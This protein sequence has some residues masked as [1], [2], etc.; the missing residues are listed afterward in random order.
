MPHFHN[1]LGTRNGAAFKTRQHDSLVA[2]QVNGLPSSVVTLIL[3]SSPV[4]RRLIINLTCRFK[5]G[6]RGAAAE[7]VEGGQR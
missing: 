3:K 5:I 4:V 2:G 7:V 1:T 6:R